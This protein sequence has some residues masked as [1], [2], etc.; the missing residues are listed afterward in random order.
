MPHVII[1][2]GPGAGK[3]TLL[4]DRGL[5]DALGLLHEVS[6][7]PASELHATLASY[8]FHTSVFVLPPWETIYTTDT[9]RDQSFADAVHEVP[10][11]TVRDRAEHVLRI[12]AEDR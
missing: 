4:F 3:T 9:G 7:L 6:P 5:V 11:L 8:R 12:L 10:R 2:G 1:T